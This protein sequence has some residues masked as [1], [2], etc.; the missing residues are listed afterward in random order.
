MSESLLVGRDSF[1][2]L[3]DASPTPPHL[4]PESSGGAS[5][6]DCAPLLGLMP[7]A[8]NSRAQ[9]SLSGGGVR[10]S[11]TLTLPSLP[12]PNWDTVV[13]RCRAFAIGVDGTKKYTVERL[14]ADQLS[15]GAVP[16]RMQS[17]DTG[18]IG[19]MLVIYGTHRGVVITVNS[20]RGAPLTD[21][22]FQAAI[23]LFNDQVDKL[24]KAPA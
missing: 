17:D 18:V 14:T 3:A 19:R 23:S 10:F 2:E 20:A 22:D 8:E 1:P 5:S 21:S 6:S 4:I 11:V 15:P 12:P 24:E 13:D 9:A 16:V 7:R